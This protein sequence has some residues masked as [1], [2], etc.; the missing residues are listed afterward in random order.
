MI[1]MTTIEALSKRI[2]DLKGILDHL[3]DTDTNNVLESEL[4]IIEDFEGIIGNEERLLDYDFSKVIPLTIKY[5][6][7]I[8][9]I[10][11]NIKDI[12]S[13]L[14]VR[15]QLG[16][17]SEEVPLEEE[18][19]N[20]FTQLIEALKTIKKGILRDLDE[21]SNV[22]KYKEEINTLEEMKGIL[23]GNSR[24]KRIT[25][26]MFETFYEGLDIF[27]M[28]PDEA[29][30]IMSG[31]YDTV[32]LRGHVKKE[33]CSEDEVISL[34]QEFISSEDMNV[35]NRMIHDHKYEITTNIDL[36]NTRDILTFL[37]ENNLLKRFR[38]SALLKITLYGKYNYIKDTI[39][40]KIMSYSEEER[41]PYFEDELATI[42]VKED[43]PTFLHRGF[44]ISKGRGNKK[45]DGNLFTTCHS[46]NIYELQENIDLLKANADLF[47]EDVDLDDMGSNIH[48]KTLSPWVLRK[49]IMLCRLFNLNR[50]MKIPVT[51]IERGDIEDKIHLAIEL[52]LLN[53][54]MAKEDIALDDAIIRNDEFQ[55]NAKKKGWN[56]VTIRDYFRRY[57]SLLAS[58]SVN[59]YAYLTYLLN[60]LG[61]EGFYNTF[62]SSNHAGKGN[63]H[64]LSSDDEQILSNQKS[65][66]DFIS[67]HF[68]S[69]WYSE[70]IPSYDEY[71]S[72][73]S[74]YNDSFKFSAINTDYIDPLIFEDDLIK[75]L[76][77]NHTIDELTTING[78]EVLH[79]NEYVYRF[80]NRLISRYK[81]LHNA[82]ILKG[83]YD[84]LTPDMLLTSIVR[85]S[86]MDEDTFKT[87]KD[88][89]LRKEPNR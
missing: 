89:I 75:T 61:Y 47:K 29:I 44:R 24:R 81:V 30:E 9:N 45:D 31:F 11:K 23:S 50:Y 28:D 10:S 14:M 77:M 86:F 49:N 57:A 22:D 19:L 33:I 48:L 74:E 12:Q 72:I 76:E 83:L 71:D 54:P 46:V 15:K 4:R 26:E 13:V 52:G 38:R 78:N 82:S 64:F 85:N 67:D 1:K 56:N 36:D 62:F 7:E 16:L 39:Y 8:P 66:D 35:F 63:N 53:S 17:S 40:P 41:E 43:G 37:K 59:E 21:L 68:M 55:A 69:D 42:W 51:L 65:I 18:Q 87:I 60:K 27:D 79:K 20:A 34:Y 2:E 3:N 6:S 84:T 32:N 73:I 88:G 5:H 80:G 70:E 58:K 25:S